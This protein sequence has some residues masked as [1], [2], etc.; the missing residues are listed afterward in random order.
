MGNSSQADG[1]TCVSRSF[2]FLALLIF[3]VLGSWLCKSVF[4]SVY[5]IPSGSMSPTLKPGDYVLV[6]Q[7]PYNLR[8]P[9]FYPFTG[10]PFPFVSADGL[11]KVNRGDIAVFDMPMYPAELHPNNKEN[12]VKRIVGLPRDTMLIAGDRY[13]LQRTISPADIQEATADLSRNSSTFAV[14]IPEQGSRLKCI[15]QTEVFWQSI[16]Q[17]DGNELSIDFTGRVLINGQPAEY[18]K[19]KQ[20]YY[21]VRG[22]NSQLSS[23]SRSWGVVPER[24]LIGRAVVKL[25]PWPPEWL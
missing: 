2:R 14:G 20:N 15:D 7:F 9:E 12:Y 22:D 6:S 17:R 16:V 23:D 19:A 5:Y 21:F 18:Y 8:S 11:G 24:N 13:F 4:F 10:I 3:V 1:T 25:W